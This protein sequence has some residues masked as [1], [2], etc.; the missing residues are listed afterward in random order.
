MICIFYKAIQKICIGIIRKKS[1]LFFRFCTII[2]I[3]DKENEECRMKK[4]AG[5]KTKKLTSLFSFSFVHNRHKW[6]IIMLCRLMVK[7]Y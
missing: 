1:F 6:K 2:S 3:A 5:A 7:K 4:H